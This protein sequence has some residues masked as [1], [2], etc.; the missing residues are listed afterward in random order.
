MSDCVV[1]MD[2][3]GAQL[4]YLSPEGVTKKNMTL[5]SHPH[6]NGHK[7]AHR[8]N[9]EEH[10]FKTL[11]TELHN[12]N[13][14][15]LFGPGIAKTHFNNYLVKHSPNQMAKKVIGVENLERLTENQILAAARKYF[16][17]YNTFNFSI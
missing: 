16:Q 13:E 5:N 14:I 12:V 2:S 8:H 3:E 1:W 11:S 17:K 6:S 10:F 4:F 15:L 7:D 9:E